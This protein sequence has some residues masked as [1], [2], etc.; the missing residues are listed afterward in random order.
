[1]SKAP[2]RSAYARAIFGARD[3]E[4]DAVLRHSLLEERFETIQIDDEAGRI[5]Q[6]LT[7]VHKPMRVVEIG[8]LFGYSTIHIARA[9]PEGGRLTGLEIDPRA[10]SAARRNL[11]A[12]GLSDRVEIIDVDAVKHLTELPDGVLDMAFIDGAK[13]YYPSYLKAL[14]R[15]LR[16]G[17]LLI[18]DDAFAEG[19]YDAERWGAGREAAGIHAYNRAVAKS[20]HFFSA[21]IP[22]ETG[23]MVS[24]RR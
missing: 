22:T 5:L 13:A 15:K 14:A 7:L 6:L 24:V 23:L 8:T 19:L 2:E 17:A 3:R 1:M 20:S 10:A 16:L 11:D 18:A 9:L 4:L 12:A 21:L